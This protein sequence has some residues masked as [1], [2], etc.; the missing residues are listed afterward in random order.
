M[1][2]A[3]KNENSNTAFLW[4]VFTAQSECFMCDLLDSLGAYENSFWEDESQTGYV[5]QGMVDVGNWVALL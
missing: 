4:G 2:I 1:G 5:R 3:T